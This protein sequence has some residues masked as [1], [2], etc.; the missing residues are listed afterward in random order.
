MSVLAVIPCL[1]EA[2]HLADLIKGLLQDELID[3]LVVAD[4]GSTD[5]SQNVARRLAQA[6]PRLKLIDNPAKIQSAG[7]NEAVAQFGADYEWLLRVD[8]HGEYPA[9][10]AQ[11][12]LQAA[13]DQAADCVVVPMLTEGHAGF[14]IAAAVAQNSVLGTGGSAH[15]SAGEGRFVDHG[16]HALIRMQLFRQ[17]GGYC[18]SMPCNEDAELDFRLTQ[19]GARIWLEPKA[20]LVYYPRS[21]PS[22][23]WRQYFKYGVGRAC[24]IK[25]HR[26]RP[27]LRQM[28]P[29]AVP[30]AILLLPFALVHPIFAVPALFWLLLCLGAGIVIGMKSGKYMAL[31]SGVAAAIMH[32][33]W[34]FGFLREFATPASQRPA[35]Y[36]RFD[37]APT[38]EAF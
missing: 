9:N 11:I 12:L 20:T 13:K 8:A 33:A 31:L 10:Y 23:L 18:Q 27:H 5:G 29:L 1:N 2:E 30:A 14:Q 15:R 36:G 26:M 21:S 7:V 32:A 24:T 19:A 34:G 35:R 16:H 37:D 3:V 6:E 22:S 4:G 38:K 25:R 28:L 17:V